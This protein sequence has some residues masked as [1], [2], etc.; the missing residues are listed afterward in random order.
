MPIGYWMLV[1]HAHMPFIRHPLYSD[2]FEERWL[3]EAIIECYL[4]ILEV[5]D[6]LKKD[7]IYCRITMSLTPPLVSMLKDPFLQ[8]RF[9]RH[10]EKLIELAEKEVIRTRHDPKLNETANYYFNTFKRY[11]RVFLET[12]GSDITKGF[13]EY[14][15]AGMLELITC[16]ATHGFFPLLG[17]Q[18]QSVI[19]QV[20]VAVKHHEYYLGFKPQGMWL[21]E[22]GYNPEDESIIKDAGIQY[23]FLETHGLTEADPTPRYGTYAPI[24]TP[25][26]LI[27]FAR[28]RESAEEVWSADVGYP[29][30]PDYREYYRDIGYDL[31]LDY[32]KPY[33]HESGIRINTG[34]KYHRITGNVPLDKKEPYSL[35]KAIKKTE[36]HASDFVG[37][38]KKQILT[39]NKILGIK[40]LVVSPYD[41][42]LYGHWWYEGPRFIENVFR[43]LSKEKDILPV[44]PMEYFETSPTIEVSSPHPSTWGMNG[45]FEYW[46]NETNHII[47]KHLHVAAK[48]MVVLANKY[49]YCERGSIQER[50]LNQALREL[51]LAQSSDWAFIMSSNTTTDYA[52]KRTEEHLSNFHR[53]C[54][55]LEK[56]VVMIRLLMHLE[57]KDNI[58]PLID[59][60]IFN[61]PKTAF[62]L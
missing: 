41:A 24:C 26:M 62:P 31:P 22:C 32:I 13:L 27:A 43:Y 53:L 5:L 10:I 15:D 12:Y 3:F 7:G 47:W 55:Q 51:L 61:T 18:R 1:L 9:L 46:L 52:I 21:P 2:P 36:I 25:S 16:G 14:R 8:S 11:R 34:I 58:F 39:V 44:T 35:E 38:R 50:V 57:N 56:G 4:P 45:Y 54:D 60:R 28:D 49:Y 48:R 29:G 40:P 20:N 42:E 30:D 19:A 37:K 6:R 33:I 59:F 23:F 17:L